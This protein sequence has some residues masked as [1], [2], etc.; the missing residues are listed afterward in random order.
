M[1][2]SSFFLNF[3]NFLVL[4]GIASVDPCFSQDARIRVDSLCD[5]THA[6]RF[7]SLDEHGTVRQWEVVGTALAGGDTLLTGVPGPA[8]A[9]CS[10]FGVNTFITSEGGFIKR[11]QGGN[12]VDL[13]VSGWPMNL[14]GA[15]DHLY[16]LTNTNHDLGYF[17]GTSMVPIAEAAGVFTSAD[18]AVHAD[19]SAFVLAGPVSG[20]TTS[21][22]KYDSGGALLASFPLSLNSTHAFGT[23]MLGEVLYVGFGST[24]PIYPNSIVPFTFLG[25]S[26]T[27][28]DPIA[29]PGDGAS[30]FDLAGCAGLSTVAVPDAMPAVQFIAFPNPADELVHL[31]LPRELRAERVEVRL[32][33]G[34]GQAV[35]AFPQRAS[36]ELLLSTGGLAPGMYLLRVLV[37]GDHRFTARVLV[38]HH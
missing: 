6:N 7:W 30:Y 5:P 12:W 19:G 14:G 10:V 38:E 13:A 34:L 27:A 24:N 25:P 18:V 36:D 21:V 3:L 20:S 28:G 9:Y 29:F 8:L 35:P 17:N 2:A 31:Q 33:D 15:N 11:Y 26:V 23:C 1:R 22:D 37:N 16:Y 32:F 4:L